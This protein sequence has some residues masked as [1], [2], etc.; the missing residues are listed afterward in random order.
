MAAHA[1]RGALGDGLLPDLLLNAAL[2]PV[3]LAPDSSVF[4]Q[5]ALGWEKSGVPSFSIHATCMSFLVALR[6]AGA[7]TLAGVNRRILIVRV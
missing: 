4:I 3:Q 5:R 1:V 6:L 2:T 7:L